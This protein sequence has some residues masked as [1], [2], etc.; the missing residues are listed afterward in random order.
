MNFE[1]ADRIYSEVAVN[2]TTGVVTQIGGSPIRGH[3]NIDLVAMPKGQSL[4]PG[5]TL[6]P[7]QA[8]VVGDIKFGGGDIKPAHTAFGQRGVTVNSE[9]NS[10][11]SV[12]DAPDTGSASIQL[13][14]RMPISTQRQAASSKGRTPPPRG[15]VR[16]S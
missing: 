2:K 4:A 13:S 10:A 3:Q 12:P 5:S 6:S 16:P 15:K 9:F 11:A 14:P 7:G 8:E 1:G